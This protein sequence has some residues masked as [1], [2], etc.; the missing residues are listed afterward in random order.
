MAGNDMIDTASPLR[1][2]IV[3][4]R[5][6]FIAQCVDL[7]L[8]GHGETPDAAIRSFVEGLIRRAKVAHHLGRDDPFELVGPPPPQYAAMWEKAA[9]RGTAAFDIPAAA[10][11]TG[12]GVNNLT[13]PVQ[14]RYALVA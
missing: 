4:E 8:A 13:F 2:V 3:H 7:D 5:G 10:F 11:T 14:G 12:K 6:C 1:V 9:A